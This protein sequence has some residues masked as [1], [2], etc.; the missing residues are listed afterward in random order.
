[1]SEG[2]FIGDP[3]G[4]VEV[5]SSLGGSVKICS[6]DRYFYVGYVEVI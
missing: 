1:M 3:G 4:S 2:T 5:P 6:S